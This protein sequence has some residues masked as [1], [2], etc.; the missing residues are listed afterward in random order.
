MFLQNISKFI[1]NYRYEQATV[2]SLATVKAAFLDFFGVTYR[3][4]GEEA[5]IIALNTID[6]I[7]SGKFNSNLNAS[8]I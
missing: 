7:F 6:E 4:V 8:I 2:E 3:G 5:S 1:S